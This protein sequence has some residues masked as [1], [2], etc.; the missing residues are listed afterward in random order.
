MRGVLVN[1]LPKY[2]VLTIWLGLN[3]FMFAYY[4]QMYD[5]GINFYYTRV[6]L[7]PGLAVARGSAACLNF[8]CML[9][10][11]PVCRNMLSLIRGWCVCC[12]RRMRRVLD[13]NITF[14]RLCAYMIVIMTMVH[15]YSHSF[16]VQFYSTAYN[17][18]LGSKPNS[19]LI[20][21]LATLGDGTNETYLDPIRKPTYPIGSVFLLTGGWT[22]VIITTALFFMVASSTEFI[23]RSYFEVFWFTHHLFIIFFG[24]LVVH[25]IG[26]QVRGQTNVNEHDPVYCSGIDI[27]D[28]P[29]DTKC[30]TTP[31]FAGNPPGTWKW[32]IGPMALYAFERVLRF[33]RFLQMV[34]VLKVVKHPSRVIELQMRKKNFKAEV[35]QYV[36]IQCPQLSFL[37]WH[38]FTLT[39]APEE[40][41][42][43]VHIRIAGDW[44]ADL[45][46]AVGADVNDQ[47]VQPAW[48][49]PR[50]AV[51]GPFGTASED[52][53]EYDIA[54]C[55]GAGIGVTPFASMLK[56]VFYKNLDNSDSLRLK[57]V[58]F[59]WICPDT[60]AFEWFGDML[61]H[62]ENQLLE[63][64]KQDL[65][66][67]NIYLTRGWTVGQ[68]KEIFIHD[69]DQHDVITGLRQKTQFGRPN[70]D[71]I[72]TKIANTHSGSEVGVFFC[73]APALST[74]LH[75][76][77]NT[78]SS[79]KVTFHYNKENF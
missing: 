28:W 66:D 23:R 67:Y 38:P 76:K 12:P 8:N 59:F 26:R 74:I 45:S 63:S 79:A 25:G 56:S 68:G 73:G 33:A 31:Q 2:L 42:F 18:Q 17:V 43:S 58:Y 51:D 54:L 29:S 22:G 41:Y 35:G 72:F 6:L 3:G 19:A 65:I 52:V 9:I 53:F 1:D 71:E 21:K 39:S 4:Y 36:F 30:S 49:M 34:E 20:V 32:V 46:K 69:E 27:D 55:V 78:H 15:Y 75:K 13:K 11:L 77:C 64:G 60:H 40:K 14:H 5:T 44:T 37:E 62:L 24:F 48:K 57:K 16:N 10:L 61:K 70:W 50:I 47:E 7:G